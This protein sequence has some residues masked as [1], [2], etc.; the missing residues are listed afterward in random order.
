MPKRT[1]RSR[2]LVVGN[3]TEDLSF[4]LPYLPRPGETLIADGRSASLGGKGLNQ[5]VI[6]ARCGV[7]VTLFAPV[8]R[9]SVADRAQALAAEEG[10]HADFPRITD[11]SDQS[12][13]TVA[14]SG[15]NTIISDAVAADALDPVAAASHVDAFRP[16]DTILVQGNLTLA[17]THAVLATAR[18]RGITTYVNPSPIRWEWSEL[19]PLVDT[20]VVNRLELATLSGTEDMEAGIATLRAA[21]C[22]R[23]LVT[24][25][26]DGAILSDAT[27][28]FRQAAVAAQV[29]DTAGA[30]DT[31][32]GVFLAREMCGDTPQQALAHAATAAA[33]TVSHEGTHGAFPDA[34]TLR[35]LSRH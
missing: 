22:G 21:G 16:R 12:V 29:V 35:A 27:G 6:A 14:R 11:R 2:L 10:I 8:G 34:A 18:D 24:L 15:E 4:R 17:T 26:A 25:G 5:A 1:D 30:G 33:I 9:D 3:V 19:W 13:I 23:V 32:C 28:T 7:A 20:V 31:F